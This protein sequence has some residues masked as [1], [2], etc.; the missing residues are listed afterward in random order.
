MDF[1]LDASELDLDALLE[2]L[3]FVASG[4]VSVGRLANVLDAS[5]TAVRKALQILA[6]DY[7]DRGLRL[8]WHDG[9]VQLT[10]APQASA[11]IERFLMLD[12]TT[13][14][15]QAAL[16]LLSIIAYLQPVTRPQLVSPGLCRHHVDVFTT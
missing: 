11:V 5:Q 3:L 7:A 14:L 9:Q 2:S 13:R 1:T 12:L 4:P 6:D 10:T 15:S 16:E 8:Q